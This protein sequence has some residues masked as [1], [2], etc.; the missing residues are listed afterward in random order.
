MRFPAFITFGRLEAVSFTHSCIYASL[1]V[2]AFVL[3]NPQPATFIFGLAHGVIWIGMSI[4]C[5][6]AARARVIPFWLAVTVCVL[7]GLGPF[8][9]SAG[10]IVEARRRA[11]GI[12]RVQGSHG[13]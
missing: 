10:F 7:G 3:G 1:L 9:G 6:A 13:G 8:F 4:T 12:V 2:C 11:Q 5:I